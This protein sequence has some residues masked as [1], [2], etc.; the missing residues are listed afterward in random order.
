[1]EQGEGAEAVN[2]PIDPV[3]FVFKHKRTGEV[4]VTS[5][6]KADYWDK[7]QWEHTASI[8]A[9]LAIQYLINVKP[10]ERDRWIRSLTEKI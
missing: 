1:M 7:K 5:G 4:V 10:R 8:N 2:N 9:C 3:A 6:C